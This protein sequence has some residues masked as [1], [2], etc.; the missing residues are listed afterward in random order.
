MVPDDKNLLNGAA[1]HSG[2]RHEVFEGGKASAALPFING[3]RC[4][5][6]EEILDIDDLE[7]MLSSQSLNVPSG[8]LHINDRQFFCKHFTS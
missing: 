6:I 4:V 7:M 1:V 8:C 2:Q 3:L 5:E